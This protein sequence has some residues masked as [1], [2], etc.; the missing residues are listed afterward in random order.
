VAGLMID[1]TATR[2]RLVNW[3]RWARSGKAPAAHCYSIEGRYRPERLTHD[4]EEDR[5][6]VRALPIDTR[7]ALLVMRAVN[8]AISGFPVRL[9]LALSAE[10]I[11]RLPPREFQGYLRRHGHGGVSTQDLEPLVLTALH[12]ARN[13]LARRGSGCYA[14]AELTRTADAAARMGAFA[15]AQQTPDID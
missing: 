5:R 7:D 1:T 11:F 3:G 10:F 14:S 6:A 9:H 13:V 8:P 2:D 15:P 12:A 4:E